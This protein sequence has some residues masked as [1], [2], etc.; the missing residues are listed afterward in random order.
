MSTF[1]TL[2]SARDAIGSKPI[3]SVELTTQLLQRLDKLEPTIQAFNSV[4]HD[5]ALE[6]AKLADQGKRP[7]PLCGVPIAVKD[8]LCTSYGLTTCSSKILANFKAPYDAM[9]I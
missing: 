9:V 2:I 1:D 4:W 7:G 8:N 6:Q 5:R 3:S